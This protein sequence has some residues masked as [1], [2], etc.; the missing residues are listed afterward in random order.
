MEIFCIEIRYHTEKCFFAALEI[1]PTEDKNQAN[2][3]VNALRFSLTK[4]RMV[5]RK[6]DNV[7]C[8]SYMVIILEV[9]HY[10]NDIH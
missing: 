5:F 8:K 6:K 7:T 2:T 1:L 3:N 4:E 9:I 10:L